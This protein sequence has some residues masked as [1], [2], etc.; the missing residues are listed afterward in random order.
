MDM[1]LVIHNK[2]NKP[3]PTE[4]RQTDNKMPHIDINTIDALVEL[5]E[6]YEAYA[7]EVCKDKHGYMLKIYG[8]HEELEPLDP[9]WVDDVDDVLDEPE[10]DDDE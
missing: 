10:E 8:S 1:R 5:I 2:G 3:Y 6:R 7:A 4:I 9:P